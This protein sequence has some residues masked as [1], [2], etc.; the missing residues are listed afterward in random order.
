MD[1]GLVRRYIELRAQED[2]AD[3]ELKRVSAEL[4]DVEELIFFT[5]ASEDVP[6]VAVNEGDKTITLYPTVTP[7]SSVPK[8]RREKFLAYCRTNFRTIGDRKVSLFTLLFSMNAN[9]KR[10]TTFVEALAEK[11][12]SVPHTSTYLTTGVRWSRKDNG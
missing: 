4:E 11:G 6:S 7:H 9:P 8:E 2:K 12:E 5:M 1:S 3:K 10:L